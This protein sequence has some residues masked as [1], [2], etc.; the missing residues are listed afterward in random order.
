MSV[1]VG[2]PVLTIMS[3]CDMDLLQVGNCPQ[4]RC[5]INHPVSGSNSVPTTLYNTLYADGHVHHRCGSK[6]PSTV[7][8]LRHNNCTAVKAQSKCFT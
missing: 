8:L 6:D 2:S 7:Q 3:G 4:M 5:N 1:P